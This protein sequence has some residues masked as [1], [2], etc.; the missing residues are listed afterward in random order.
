M[1]VILDN[2]TNS[3]K[4]LSSSGPEIQS[5]SSGH[6]HHFILQYIKPP[7]SLITDHVTWPCHWFHV[8][9]SFL[10]CKMWKRIS[11]VIGLLCSAEV[12]GST[13]IIPCGR[14][15][16]FTGQLTSCWVSSWTHHW[17]EAWRSVSTGHSQA[18]HCHTSVCWAFWVV[19]MVASGGQWC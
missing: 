16:P 12:V 9:F 11:K 17:Q 10:I 2:L 14:E 4:L 8:Y 7:A 5:G 15:I 6:S 1:T 13:W 18:E 3:I 19:R